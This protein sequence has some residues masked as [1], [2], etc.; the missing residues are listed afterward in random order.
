MMDNLGGGG[1]DDVLS[2]L[3]YA[4][5]NIIFMDHD[6]GQAK[7]HETFVVCFWI[8]VWSQNQFS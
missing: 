6:L 3:Q 2:I 4:N 7:K 8:V 5:D 1:V